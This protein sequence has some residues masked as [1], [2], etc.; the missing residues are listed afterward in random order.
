MNWTAENLASQSG[1][2][3]L[4]TGANTGLGFETS[5]ALAKKGAKIFL[6]GRSEQKLLEAQQRIV[7]AVPD[8][9]LAIA[10]L[11]LNSVDSVKSFAQGFL[12]DNDALDVLINNAGIMF[13]PAA[14]SADGF[15]SQFGVNFIGHYALS[16]LLF[17]LL[18]KSASG[19]VVT[20]SSI[21]HRNSQIDFDNLKLEKPFN[22]FREYG[23]SK[24]AD[25]VFALELGRRIDEHDL[26]VLS[27]AC[28]PGV[29]KTE[30]L[31]NDS[32]EM[33]NTVAYMEADQG[34]LPSL[35]AATESL[36]SGAYIG[37]DGADEI[38]GYPAPAS[39]DTYAQDE[40]IGRQLWAYAES[41][42]GIHF[43]F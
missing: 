18:K 20:L 21:A 25:L 40:S 11:D 16:A 12:R 35:Y 41:E 42:T 19:R 36:S 14:K 2:S 13:P 17:P 4:I 7:S 31:R 15:E 43:D 32:P 34:A 1:K 23:Q 30:L 24:A 9:Q 28:H 37:P 10:V 5:L 3:F 26:E 29:S 22:K 8:A 39:I 38:N 6:A 33:I 27:V